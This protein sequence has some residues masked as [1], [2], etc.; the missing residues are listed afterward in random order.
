MTPS[1]QRDA[2]RCE[3]QRLDLEGETQGPKN[4]PRR[5][6]PEIPLEMAKAQIGRTI[7]H[8]V[9]VATT[10]GGGL[11]DVG[12]PAQVRRVCAGDFT[13]V[14][15]RAYARDPREFVKKLAEESGRFDVRVTLDERRPA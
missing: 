1:I 10:E 9:K 6:L 2:A 5:N 8:M 3:V 13:E 7:A 14:I 12:D 15:A 11:K 4:G